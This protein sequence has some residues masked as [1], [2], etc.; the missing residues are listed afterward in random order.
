MDLY[1]VNAAAQRVIDFLD[2]V[3]PAAA[4]VARVRYSPLV[5]FDDMNAYGAAVVLGHLAPMAAE[6]QVGVLATLTELQ[7]NNRGEYSLV[8]GPADL[9]DAEQSAQVSRE[10]LGSH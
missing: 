6:I 9:L 4:E 5:T 1:G 2:I 7:T 10:S 8:L 3:D